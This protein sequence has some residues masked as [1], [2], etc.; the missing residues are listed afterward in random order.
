MN[1]K[2]ILTLTV[3]LL[4]GAATLQA[5]E[6]KGRT[7]TVRFGV[8]LTAGSNSYLNVGALPGMLTSYGTQAKSVGWT[9][10][11][12]AFGIEGSLIFCDP[13]ARERGFLRLS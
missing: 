4:V 2:S 6:Q 11:A 8:A 10:K 1:I 12:L 9:D 13:N 3:A 7:E 5:Q